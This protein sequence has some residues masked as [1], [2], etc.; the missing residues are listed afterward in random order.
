MTNYSAPRGNEVFVIEGEVYNHLS[1][2]HRAVADILVSK[3][4]CIIEEAQKCE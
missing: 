1:P 2:L 3:G 4:R